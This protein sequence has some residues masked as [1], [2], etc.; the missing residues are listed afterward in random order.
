MRTETLG[1]SAV[2]PLTCGVA[3]LLSWPDAASAR[4]AAQPNALQMKCLQQAGASLDP[5]TKRWT[6]YV[7]ERDGM[8]RSDMFR[9]CL[10][11]GDRKK[12]NAIAVPERDLSPAGSLP[13]R[14]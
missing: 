5:V 3:I 6:F 12:A 11:G 9:L 10:A 4:R 13:S 14:Y 8:S 2:L 7:T 1:R